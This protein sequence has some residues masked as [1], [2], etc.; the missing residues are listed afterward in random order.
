MS[1]TLFLAAVLAAPAAGQAPDRSGERVIEVVGE[2]EAAA[3]P[4]MATVTTGV[5]SEGPTARE[6]LAVNN[7]TMEKIMGVLKEHAIAPRDIQTS[8]FNVSPVYEHDPKGRAR[9]K[10]VGYRVTN[11]VRVRVRELPALGK[12]LDA[13]VQAGS[14]EVSGVQFE[15]SEPTPVLDRAREK[16]VADARHRAEVYAQAAGARVGPLRRIS[17][18]S[19]SRPVARQHFGVEL[20]RAAA[21]VP[22]AEGEE[23]FR[24]RV[25]M[26][27]ELQAFT[28]P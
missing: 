23:E 4:D 26:T 17:E 10:L 5:T 1:P 11:Q 14:N 7:D 15:V 13:L 28:S 20:A 19:W 22:I 16:A 25:H 12:V 24:V 3:A 21:A 6:A 8:H 2:G 18:E 9:P 27:F